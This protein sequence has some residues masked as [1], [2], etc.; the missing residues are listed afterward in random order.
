M[1]ETARRAVWIVAVLMVAVVIGQ[2]QGQETQ[3]ETGNVAM[4][5]GVAITRELYGIQVGQMKQQAA[6]QGRQLDSAMLETIQKDALDSL[7]NEELLFKESQKSGIQI[8][9]SAV[10]GQID[11]FKKQFPT[12]AAFQE[13]LK[14]GGLTETMLRSHIEKGMAIRRLVQERIVDSI[15]IAEAESRNFYDAHPEYFQEPETVKASHILVKVAE[16][17]DAAQKTAA[18]Q[19]IELIQQKLKNG[20]DFT[21]LARQ[22]SEGPSRSNGGDLGY[23]RRGQM[24]GPFEQAAFAMQPGQISDKV[25]TQ[26]GYH[27]IKVTDKK[28]A[29]IVSYTEAREKIDGHLKRVKA[30][31]EVKSYIRSL[32]DAADIQLLP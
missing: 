25:V 11:Q 27:L 28:A 6:R 1:P 12:E 2:A 26:F 20:E 3:T 17:A 18:D 9:K 14:E 13:Q 29:G 31:Q 5:N 24:V 4:V 8:E 23:F 15:V 7:I 21:A 16:G 22:F 30:D 10:E 32:R 19:K